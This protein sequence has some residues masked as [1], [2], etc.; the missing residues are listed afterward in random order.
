MAMTQDE[1]VRKLVM[2]LDEAIPNFD[3]FDRYFDG[4]V[5]LAFLAPEIAEATKDRLKP[6]TVPWPR[7][8]VNAI[9]ERLTVTG[10]RTGNADDSRLWDLWQRDNLDEFSIHAHED[11]LV[12]GRSFL[13]VWATED[14]KA[15]ITVES[16]RECFVQYRPGSRV[17]QYGIRRYIDDDTIR[18]DLFMPDRIVRFT[19]GRATDSTVLLGTATFEYAETIPNPLGRVPLIPMVNRPRTMRP[20]GTSELSDLLPL[21]DG[22]AKLLTDLMVGSEFTALPRR[23]AT[24]F[25]L[26]EKL[27]EHG[28]PTGEVDMSKAFDPLAG[29]TWASEDPQT[30]FGQLPGASLDGFT[31]A[32]RNLTEALAAAACLPSHY[33]GVTPAVPASADAIRSSEAALVAKVR[34]RQ[35]SYEPAWEEA[36][37]LAWAIETGRFDPRLNSLEVRWA[38]PATRTIAQDADAVLKLVAAEVL[39]P[40]A[41][42]EL[43]GFSPTQVARINALRTAAPIKIPTTTEGDPR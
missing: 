39:P 43:I 28:Q 22:L 42:L 38:D 15:R 5:P 19:G 8:V 20:Y 40:D 21:F 27:D 30:S 18:L 24:G 13:L 33:L 6:L 23:Y 10:F 32:V 1:L 7:V 26:P 2:K 11:A 36:V 29:R 14:G 4:E 37:R 34:E 17:R 35:R 41:G 12:H 25:P 16:G 3:K 9:K 31:N